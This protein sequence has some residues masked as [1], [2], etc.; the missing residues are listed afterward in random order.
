MTVLPEDSTDTNLAISKM[1][2]IPSPY[3]DGW[4]EVS[5]THSIYYSLYGNPKGLP[6]ICPHG[7]PGSRSKPKYANLYDLDRFNVI[8]FDQ[9]GCGKSTPVA[10]TKENTTWDLVN[11]IEKLRIYLGIDSWYM[12]GP[13]W[14]STLVL[15]YAQQYPKRVRSILLHGVFLGTKNED[16]WV[17]RFGANQIFPDYFQEFSNSL[18]DSNEK[19][20]TEY[21]YKIVMGDD[22]ELQEKLIPIFNKWEGSLLSLEPQADGVVDIEQEINSAKIYLHYKRNNYF[23]RDG[24]ILFP[25]NITKIKNI[26]MMIVNGRYDMVTPMITAW[27]LHQALPKSKLEIITLAGHHGS[28]PQLHKAL[29]TLLRF[30]W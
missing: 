2:N 12:Y 22:R 18:P 26:P 25:E 30:K 15:L 7:G 28:D 5:K 20:L 29:K 14:G 9:R 11:D 10:Q 19:N 6:I 3:S 21:F 23:L 16:D 27:Q 8:F 17:Y 24:E 4:L 1:Q 13:S